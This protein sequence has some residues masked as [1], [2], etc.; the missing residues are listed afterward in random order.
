MESKRWHT[1]ISGWRQLS[2]RRH[3]QQLFAN[4]A[5]LG[6][7]RQII[8]NGLIC[9]GPIFN[10]LVDFQRPGGICRSFS[11]AFKFAGLIQIPHMDERGKFFFGQ[12]NRP[13]VRCWQSG[14]GFLFDCNSGFFANKAGHFIV[15]S[16]DNIGQSFHPLS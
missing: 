9:L 16:V 3:N 10:N 5:A 8:D 14:D 6:A 13:V 11:S 7:V 4:E 1:A 2:I 15:Q 12:S